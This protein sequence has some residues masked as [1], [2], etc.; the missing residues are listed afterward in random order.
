MT[1]P[2][3]GKAAPEKD[4]EISRAPLTKP[5][6]AIAGVIG[7]LAMAAG[8]LA[9]FT[10]GNDVGTG[11]L[12]LG[13]AA[14]T[15]MSVQGTPLV[16]IGGDRAAIE[17]ERRRVLD[18]VIATTAKESPNQLPQ[19]ID[20]VARV[21]GSTTP[22]GQRALRGLQFQGEVK[23]ALMAKGWEVVEATNDGGWDLLVRDAGTQPVQIILKWFEKP[24][25]GVHWSKIE[26]RALGHLAEISIDPMLVVV[27]NLTKASMARVAVHG[28][29][30]KFAVVSWDSPL[31][32]ITFTDAVEA[33]ANGHPW[34]PK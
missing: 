19:V 28:L 25:D 33:L 23:D 2:E 20:A 32:V 24:D 12:L 15:L 34:A 4:V 5:E 6:R 30:S 11:A 8:T 21:E 10:S 18:D 16:K 14:F 9:T 31:S 1:D 29:D 27:N 3:P 26:G 22:M 13:G 17:L 7:G